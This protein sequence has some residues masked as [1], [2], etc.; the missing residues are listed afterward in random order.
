MT[1]KVRNAE[2]PPQSFGVI[3]KT[4]PPKRRKTKPPPR[5]KTRPPPLFAPIPNIARKAES[6]SQ[7]LTTEKIKEKETPYVQQQA[8]RGDAEQVDP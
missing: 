2:P 7:L 6:T 4:K 1:R 3:R 8:T 5:R